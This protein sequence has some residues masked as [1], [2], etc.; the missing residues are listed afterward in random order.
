M[1]SSKDLPWRPEDQKVS[2]LMGSYWSNFAKTGNPNGRGLPKWPEYRSQDRYEVMHLLAEP[3]AAP[4]GHRA[5]YELLDRLR[6]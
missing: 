4:D 2:D 1:L 3:H 5:R 6:K